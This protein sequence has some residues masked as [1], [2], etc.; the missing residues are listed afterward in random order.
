MKFKYSQFNPSIP[1]RFNT[2]VL[3]DFDFSGNEQLQKYVLYWLKLHLTEVGEGF[4]LYG[5][6]GLGKTMLVSIISRLLNGELYGNCIFISF[7]DLLNN[8]RDFENRDEWLESVMGFNYIIIDD[9][10]KN[11]HENI[12]TGNDLKNFS[13]FIDKIYNNSKVLICTSMYDKKF[14]LDNLTGWDNVLSRIF[15]MCEFVEVKGIDRRI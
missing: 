15:Q 4:C 9:L 6:I 12:Y 1:K 7:S 10:F 13:N 8:M 2:N 14:L 3:S 11:C 5:N